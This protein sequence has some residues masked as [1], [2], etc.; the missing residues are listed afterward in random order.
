MYQ[1][2]YEKRHIFFAYDKIFAKIAFQRE[3]VNG[4]T[5]RMT[6]E[7][8]KREPLDIST[9]YSFKKKDDLFGSNFPFPQAPPQA[10]NFNKSVSAELNLAWVPNQKYTTYPKWKLIEAPRYPVFTLTLQTAIGNNKG[11][12]ADFS[13]VAMSIE[14]QSLPV[15]LVGYSEIRAEFGDFLSKKNVSYI[16]YKHFNNNEFRIANSLNYM[17]GFLALPYYQYSTK[18]AYVMAH[19]QHHFEGFLLG[20]IPLIRKLGFKEIVRVAYL[21]TPKL[22]DYA[23]VGVGLDNIGYGLFRVL[24]LDLS[25]VYRD[26]KMDKKPIWMFAINMPLN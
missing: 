5:G 4:L 10:I 16:D 21:N 3:I 8:A 1:A 17:K 9:Q 15:G 22:G 14:Q 23:E 11:D 26:G 12:F 6:I 24:R 25:W 2:L 19:W 13:R 18:N 7:A 20:K